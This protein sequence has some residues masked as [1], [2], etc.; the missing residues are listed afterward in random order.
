MKWG[1]EGIRRLGL[2]ELGREKG[3][4]LFANP[5]AKYTHVDIIVTLTGQHTTRGGQGNKI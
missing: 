3:A 4:T 5:V 2:M 1:S